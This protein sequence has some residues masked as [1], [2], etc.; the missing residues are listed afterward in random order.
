MGDVVTL[1]EK[2]QKTMEAGEALE[3]QEKLA[4][5]TFTLEDMLD[6]YRRM[7]KMGSLQSIMEMIPGL[8]GSGAE[9]K[10]DEKEMKQGGSHDPL[11][12]S[13]GAQELPHHR[14]PEP[15][16]RCPGKRHVGLRGEQV[17]EK[18]RE[19]VSHDE[20]DVAE[21]EISGPGAVTARRQGIGGGRQ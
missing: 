9:D 19:D 14:P 5:E 18:I 4:S 15:G 10:I 16:A 3:L 12:D 11:H 6:Q 21:L 8:K 7:R 17:L 2:A 13:D 20:K 1:V